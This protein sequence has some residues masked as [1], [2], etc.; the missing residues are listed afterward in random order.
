MPLICE[1]N[2]RMADSFR[3][4]PYDGPKE[5]ICECGA[6]GCTARVSL[7][8]PEYRALRA[9]PARLALAPGHAVAEAVLERHDRFLLVETSP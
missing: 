7:T 3:R 1:V 4:L 5:F 8:L 6:V 9:H 2:D